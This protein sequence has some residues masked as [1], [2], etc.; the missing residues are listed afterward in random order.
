[1][2][3][4]DRTGIIFEGSL[5]GEGQGAPATSITAEHTDIM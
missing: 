3:E 2:T 4:R 1:M 5:A